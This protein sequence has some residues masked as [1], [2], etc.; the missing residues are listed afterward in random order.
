MVIHIDTDGHTNTLHDSPVVY[1]VK[2]VL[3]THFLNV[4]DVVFYTSWYTC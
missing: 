4:L 2:R 1:H 3:I